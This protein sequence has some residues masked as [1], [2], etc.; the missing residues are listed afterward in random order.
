MTE[1]SV[2]RTQIDTG[3]PVSITVIV[4]N[5]G[6]T[7]ERYNVRPVLFGEVIR[8]REIL[9]PAGETRTTRFIVRLMAVGEY[10]MRVGNETATI[11]VTDDGT[12]TPVSPTQGTAS[13]F[14]VLTVLVTLIGLG[15]G[16]LRHRRV[17]A[18]K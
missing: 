1:V 14:T 9:I 6:T 12:P 17:T 7:P 2:N 3:D 16:A 5:T 4:E 15:L 13:G 18:L 11:V 8:D 10:Q